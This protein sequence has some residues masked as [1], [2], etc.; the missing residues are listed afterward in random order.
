MM[1]QHLYTIPYPIAK[2]ERVIIT[3]VPISQPGPSST[4]RYVTLRCLPPPLPPT[5]KQHPGW[6]HGKIQLPSSFSSTLI[7]AVLSVTTYSYYCYYCYNNTT[8]TTNETGSKVG[9]MEF[10]C[11][12][13]RGWAARWAVI[14]FLFQED[15]TGS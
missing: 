3:A 1:R 6:A 4:L 9:G 12:K 2:V 8:T 11:G 10:R 7:E 14:K 15:F 13:W 5:G